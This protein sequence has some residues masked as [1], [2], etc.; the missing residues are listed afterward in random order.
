M[1]S[2]KSADE[3]L[4]EIAER[5]AIVDLVTRYC[6]VIWRG[7]LDTYPTLYTEDG[8]LRWTNPDREPVRGHAAL[9]EMIEPMV[10][11]HSPAPVCP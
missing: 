10:V 11:D 7:E 2:G 6:H 9:R 4:H 3:L 1:M 5:E 8:I